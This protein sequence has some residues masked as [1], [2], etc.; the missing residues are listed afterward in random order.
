[1]TAAIVQLNTWT[2]A[3]F[4]Y[5][6]RWAGTDDTGDTVYFDFTG[7]NLV[8]DI[9]V[10]PEDVEAYVRLASD[11]TLET[12]GGIDI[13]DPDTPGGTNLIEFSITITRTELEA[14]PPNQY[15]HSLLLVYPDGMRQDV[16]RGDLIHQDGPTR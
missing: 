10:N 3:D 8:M 15:T 7:Y 11:P 12:G 6:F 4:C 13:Y 2:D 14:M 16:W 1:M 9:R 5:A